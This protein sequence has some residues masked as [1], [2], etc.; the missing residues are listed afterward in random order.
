MSGYNGSTKRPRVLIVG[1][2]FGGL[3]LARAL[4]RAPVDI[5]LI[6]RNNYHTFQ[7]L[8]YQVAT[9]ALEPEEIAHSVRGIFQRQRNFRFRMG[10]VTDVRFDE[11]RVI[12]DGRDALDYDYLVLA[13]GAVTN[14]FGVKGAAEHSF[15]LKG[16]ELALA[17]RSHIIRQFE[18]ADRAEFNVDDG[19]LTFAAVGGGPTGIETTGALVELIDLV[20]AKDFRDLPLERVRVI[21]LEATDGLLAGFDE[22]LQQYT[23]RTLEKRGVE[24][25]LGDP[26]VEVTPRGV[27]L[28]SGDYIPT[29]TVI[30]SAG[31]RTEALSDRLGLEQDR[32]GRIAVSDD[33]SLPGRP[34]VFAIGD[35]AAARDTDGS[36][37]P[38]VAPVAIQGGR[39]VARRITDDLAG[40]PAAPFRFEDPGIMATIGRNSGVVQLPSGVKATGFVAWMMWLG[41]H[42][43]QLIGFRNRLNVLVNWAWNYFTYDRS[44]R[45]ITHDF[46]READ[47]ARQELSE[48]AR[49][50][51]PAPSASKALDLQR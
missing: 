8:L 12:V 47:E 25:R 16:I 10:E 49:P 28:R 3:E 44:A 34:N 41:L 22:R 14:F 42:L 5:L 48:A 18:I 31:V 30:W 45:L 23:A 20:L 11:R 4:R 21:L 40:R 39:H 35:I 7:P 19:R 33:L 17:L 27:H 24:I 13:A 2:G 15:D 37:L 6:D 32:G 51:V 1:A 36:L 50:P 26:V 38:Q 9:A 29:H 43:V 46:V